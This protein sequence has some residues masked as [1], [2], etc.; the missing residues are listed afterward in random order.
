MMEQLMTGEPHNPARRRSIKTYRE[1]V[2]DKE[3]R[4]EELRDAY[5]RARSH[6]EAS[7]IL[8]RYAQRFSISEAVLERLQLP[9]LLDRSVSADPSLPCSPFPL[10]L[11]LTAS[12]TTPDPFDEDPE[13][14]LRFLRQQSAPPPKFTSTLEARIEEFPKE[15]PHQRPQ[16]RSRSSE[17][18]ASRGLSSKPLPLL[19]PKPFLQSRPSAPEQWSNKGDGFHRV[20]GDVGG[21]DASPGGHGRE[22]L[23][24]FQPSPS[25]HSPSAADAPSPA[26]SPHAAGEG[27]SLTSTEAS[28]HRGGTEAARQEAGRQE[29][30]EHSTPPSRPTSLP[31]ELQ[32]AEESGAG[33]GKQSEGAPVDETNSAPQQTPSTDAKDEREKSETEV[34]PGVDPQQSHTVSLQTSV[35]VSQQSSQQERQ[36][37]PKSSPPGPSG[38]HPPTEK[39]AEAAN[40]LKS[41]LAT[42]NPKLRWDFFA[43]PEGTEKECRGNEKYQREQRKLKEEWEKAQQEVAEEGRKYHEEERRILEQTVT[44]LTPRSS[45]VSSPSRG[46]VSSAPEPQDTIVRSLADWERKQELLERQSGSTA[47][48]AEA[49][50][51]KN[52]RTSDI[53]TADDSMKTGRS[54]ASQGS[55]QAETLS[56]NLQNGQ[57][58]PPTSAKSTPAKKQAEA[59]ADKTS[60]PAGDRRVGPA[61]SNAGRGGS[62]KAPTS[63]ADTVAPP[64]NRSV[65]GKKLCSSCGQPLGKG[66]AMIIETLSLYFHIQ[67]FK[68]GVCKGQLGDTTTG[69]DVRIRN[70]LLNCHQCYIRSRSAG[71]P[72]TL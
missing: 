41:P 31:E 53:S 5:R 38:Y 30:T 14:P 22:S 16:I 39:T 55:S 40:S 4:E 3:R 70:G 64:P 59:P 7:C 35:A 10:S 45:A 48:S 26:L 33:T 63:P 71:Q 66:A 20:N 15:A 54:L 9:K 19:M 49:K 67:C 65:S 56:H 42:S 68:C 25:L 47:D 28:G 13:G 6:E 36:S 46:E 43:P 18:P 12:P 57:K 62:S 32:K 21:L 2:E 23:N 29:V 60:R 69:T 50:Q 72:T 58:A 1:I 37:V 11:S 61:D 44:P 52:D 51:R 34:K 27:Q 24:D 8:Q 17:P